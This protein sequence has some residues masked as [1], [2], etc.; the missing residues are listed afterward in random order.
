VT[1]RSAGRL[2][3][4]IGWF[5]ENIWYIEELVDEGYDIEIVSTAKS[6]LVALP[7]VALPKG[8]ID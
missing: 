6:I 7:V 4:S 2:K 5:E 1:K 3:L 8:A